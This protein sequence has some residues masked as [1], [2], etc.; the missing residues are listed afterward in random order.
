MVVV[1]VSNKI[2]ADGILKYFSVWF[3]EKVW[4][5]MWIFYLVARDSDE[6]SKIWA[7]IPRK[8]YN[9]KAQ[10]SRGTTTWRDEE[11]AGLSGSVQCAS[12]WWSG[13][14]FDPS[15]ILWHSLFFIYIDHEIIST[16]ILSLM[17]TQEGSCQ[18]LVKEYAYLLGKVYVRQ[19]DQNVVCCEI[20]PVCRAFKMN[21]SVVNNLWSVQQTGSIVKT[22]NY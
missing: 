16:V 10:L 15:Q 8:C 22:L 13:H 21:T 9:H 1:A 11:Q 2:V 12:D 6:M 19:I 4:H 18:F 5:F 14:R 3:W 7:K 17:L 20:L